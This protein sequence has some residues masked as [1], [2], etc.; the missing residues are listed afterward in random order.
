MCGRQVLSRDGADAAMVALATVLVQ[1]CLLQWHSFPPKTL[2][3]HS[4]CVDQS[5]PLSGGSA[6]FP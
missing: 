2:P 1:S 4:Q 3:W 5:A 6:S